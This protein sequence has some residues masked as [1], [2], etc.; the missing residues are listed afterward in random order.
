MA[1]VK[2]YN[3]TGKSTGDVDL[4]DDLFAV[5]VRAG[6]V[7]EAIVAKEANGRVQYA[8]VK[9]RSEVAGTGKKPWKQKG[10]GRARHGSRRSP[11]WIGGGITFGPN[12][13]RNFA[14][15]INKKARRKA[16]KM[17]LSS[18]VQAETLVVIE[19][20][21]SIEGKTSQMAKLRQVLPGA[22]RKTL[23]VTTSEEASVANA[24]KNLPKVTPIA[25][26]SLNVRDVVANEYIICSKA[27]LEVI[28]NTF[29]K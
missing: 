21:S 6:L 2:L 26:H 24:A 14:K 22:G 15:K 12:P 4:S 23:V 20:F 27:A 8:H 25:A 17:A 13:F 29:A 7:H 16:L 3:A 11:I 19:D 28:T 1:K 9:D 5:E 18:K 10:T